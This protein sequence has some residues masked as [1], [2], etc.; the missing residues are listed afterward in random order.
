[1]KTYEQNKRGGE[2]GNL[3]VQMKG[4]EIYGREKT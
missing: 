4:E 1:M 3:L 2:S